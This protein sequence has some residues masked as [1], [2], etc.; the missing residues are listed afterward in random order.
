[1]GVKWYLTVVLI[2]I[3]LAVNDVGYLFMCLFAICKFSL[4]K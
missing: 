3:F 4:E 1:M 2:C